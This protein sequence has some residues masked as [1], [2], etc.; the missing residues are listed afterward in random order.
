LSQWWATTLLMNSPRCRGGGLW[1]DGGGW[2][3]SWRHSVPLRR[4]MLFVRLGKKNNLH[5]CII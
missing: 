5:R 3:R 2:T 4:R 1:T